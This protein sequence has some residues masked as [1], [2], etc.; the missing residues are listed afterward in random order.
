MAAIKPTGKGLEGEEVKVHRIRITLTSQNVSA[1]E[2]GAL[3]APRA[4][5]GRTRGEIDSRKTFSHLVS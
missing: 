4:V 2:K 1:L 5:Q 3:A